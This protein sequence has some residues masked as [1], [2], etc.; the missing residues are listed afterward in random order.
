MNAPFGQTGTGTTL[1]CSPASPL[2]TEP[3]MKF[4]SRDAMRWPDLG[5]VMLISIGPRTSGTGG[6]FALAGGSGARGITGIA[7]DGAE[8]GD[9][10]LHDANSSKQQKRAL[11]LQAVILR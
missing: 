10:G 7:G 5:I 9:A 1:I 4:E 11:N 3:K 2:P 6:S 8:R